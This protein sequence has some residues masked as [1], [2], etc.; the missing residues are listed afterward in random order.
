MSI[1]DKNIESNDSFMELPP[2]PLNIFPIPVRNM[3]KDAAKAFGVPIEIVIACFLALLSALVGQALRIS[4]KGSWSEAGNLWL[5]LVA[6]SGVGKTPCMQEFF[7]PLHILEH[8]E[9][10]AYDERC[11]VYEEAVNAKRQQASKDPAVKTDLPEKPRRKQT[12]MNDTTIE[13]VGD[14]LSMNPK[15]IQVQVDEISG[16]MFDMDKYT[17][18]KGGAKPRY[19]S[20]HTGASW[21]ID[22]KHGGSISIPKAYISIFGGIQPGMMSKVFN[23]KGNTDIDSGFIPRFL[24]IR[25]VVDKPTLWTDCS[26]SEQSKELLTQITSNLYRLEV[27]DNE[28]NSIVKVTDEAKALYV[29]WHDEIADEAFVTSNGAWLRKLQAHALRICLLLHCLE[30]FKDGCCDATMEDDCHSFVTE[31]TM[32]RALMLVDWLKIHQEQCWE[33]FMPQNKDKAN[34]ME[35]AFMKVIADLSCTRGYEWKITNKELFQLVQEELGLHEIKDNVLGK[36]AK[37]LEIAACFI[38]KDRGRHITEDI[39][40]HFRNAVGAVDPVWAPAGTGGF[41]DI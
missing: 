28:Q 16:F 37:E 13:A 23:I 18:S 35:Y 17:T 29:R 26:F 33:L 4:I 8:Q 21:V 9:K 10:L 25:A 41:F 11:R 36:A 30:V 19:L 7:R 27:S 12:I 24:F 14:R 6:K 34:P 5:V 2:V 31:D 32:R 40:R 20:S 38:G 3:L 1:S 15:G 22:R 39:V